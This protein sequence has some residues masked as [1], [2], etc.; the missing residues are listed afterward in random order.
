LLLSPVVFALLLFPWHSRRSPWIG[1]GLV[2]VMCSL[3]FT[4]CGGGDRE[5][6]MTVTLPAQSVRGQGTLS[7]SLAGPAAPLAG[8]LVVV[9][10]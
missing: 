9:S 5:V 10:P 8:P 2:L 3:T 4:S 1:L 7:G 6:T